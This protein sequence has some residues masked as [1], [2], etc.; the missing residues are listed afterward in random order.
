MVDGACRR[1]DAMKRILARVDRFFGDTDFHRVLF[2]RWSQ[3]F[4][5]VVSV[6]S[7]V[8]TPSWHGPALCMYRLL[9]G[10]PC[11]GCGG[12]R[13]L[14]HLAHGRLLESLEFHPFGIVILP[15]CLV[16]GSSLLW[17]QSWHKRVRMFLNGHRRTVA[18]IYAAFIALFVAFGLGR[19]VY[20]AVAVVVASAGAGR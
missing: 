17:P 11:P 8:L 20:Y 19:L 2:G 15:L 3:A 7:F 13:S 16:M 10:L 12:T 1:F 18:R 6:V 14:V 5:L 9:T 4:G